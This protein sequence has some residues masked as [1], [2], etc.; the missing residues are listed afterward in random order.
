[1]TTRLTVKRGTVAA[2]AT[3]T[4]GALVF[5]YCK[6]MIRVDDNLTPVYST[7]RTQLG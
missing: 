6:P 1:M 7:L 5:G 3:T 2:A 4:S